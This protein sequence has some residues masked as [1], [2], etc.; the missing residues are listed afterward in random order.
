MREQLEALKIESLAKLTAASSIDELEAVRVQTLGK[1]GDLTKILRGLGKVSAEERPK[2]GVLANEIKVAFNQALEAQQQILKK[3]AMEARL[4]EERLDITLPGRSPAI[5]SIHPISRALAELTTIFTHMG[6]PPATGPEVE[7]DWYNF[8]ALNIPDDHPA[9]EMH[10]TFYLPPAQDGGKRVLRT[11]TSSVQVHFMENRQPPIRMIAPGKVFRCDSDITHTPMFH[12]IEG[13]LVD[14]DVDFGQL[15]GLLETF[16]HRFFE[17]DLPVR[18]RPSFFPF[19]EPSAEA[20]MGCIFCDAKGCRICKNTGWIE[21]LGCGMIHPNVLK[22]V[23]IDTE[24]YAGF[25]FGMGV[26]RLAMLKYGINDLR[27]FF[28]NDL[29]FLQRHAAVGGE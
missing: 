13:I 23:D 14:E 7:N 22:N 28:E 4:Q 8:G 2:L 15:K 19:T 27:T 16:L 18:F 21:I 17:R 3:S 5:G 24:K 11:H 9:R 25:A 20:D 29:R 6:F 10:D 12:Q 26:E 1:K